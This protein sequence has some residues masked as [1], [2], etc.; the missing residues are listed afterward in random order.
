MTGAQQIGTTTTTTATTET[1][2]RGLRPLLRAAC[3]P[4]YSYAR[5]LESGPKCFASQREDTGLTTP[6]QGRTRG[7]NVQTQLTCY[8]N[9]GRD[10]WLQRFALSCSPYVPKIMRALQVKQL[11]PLVCEFEDFYEQISLGS[12]IDL[13][14][15]DLKYGGV[16]I[17]EIK[18]GG[19]NYFF[20]DSGQLIRPR[21]LRMFSNC[22][23]NQA[24][25]QLTVYRKML[26]DHYPYVPIS[27][28]LVAQV[29]HDLVHFHPL[30]G[31]FVSAAN[32]L[33][34]AVARAP[35]RRAAAAKQ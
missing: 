25:C 11:L 18:V 31:E 13:L 24:F 10:T 1:K 29:K 34:W 3:F 30:P 26:A 32:S 20:K 12:S 4:N 19:E 33:Y 23:L 9:E 28:C 8:V 6:W 15:L 17:I 2:L 14:C 21:E 22:P 5:A 7:K 35:R 27:R 16:C